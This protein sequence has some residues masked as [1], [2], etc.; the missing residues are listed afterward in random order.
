[1]RTH[2]PY[3]RI[4]GLL[5]GVLGA[6]PVAA[7]DTGLG[8]IAIATL[9]DPAAARQAVE[10]ALGAWQDS[11]R[12]ERTTAAIRPIMFVEQQQPPGQRLLG[13]D[14]LGETPSYEDEG[15]RRFL[16]RLTLTEPEDSVVA[17]YYV[18]GQDP[19]WVYR[20]EDFDMIMHMEKSMMPP[21]P[22]AGGTVGPGPDPSR[23]RDVGES[24]RIEGLR[25]VRLGPRGPARGSTRGQ[26]VEQA[27]RCEPSAQE[28]LHE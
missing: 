8:P 1:M 27:I 22:P 18:F 6:A 24:G 23:G 17:A 4:T 25:L 7:C 2:P 21:P 13:F 14:V 12:I 16:V 15:Y 10:N 19:I 9:P 11:P 28:P 3:L 26:P 20:A 5:A